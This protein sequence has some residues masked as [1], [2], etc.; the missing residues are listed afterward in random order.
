VE[1]QN[2][3]LSEKI[4]SVE[5]QN[6]RLINDNGRVVTLENENARLSLDNRQLTQEVK[7][8]KETHEVLLRQANQDGDTIKAFESGN[9]LLVQEKMK[10]VGEIKR[11][12]QQLSSL[13]EDKKQL[14]DTASH[15]QQENRRLDA[16][17][18][19]DAATIRRLKQELEQETAKAVQL[20][21][22][23][24]TLSAAI[25]KHTED[26]NTTAQSPQVLPIQVAGCLKPGGSLSWGGGDIVLEK[27]EMPLG[28]ARSE[29]QLYFRVGDDRKILIGRRSGSPFVEKPLVVTGTRGQLQFE[30]IDITSVLGHFPVIWE[31]SGIEFKAT[32]KPLD[33]GRK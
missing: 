28:L 3:N 20:Q 7:E 17:N 29:V 25:K 18:G 2:W 6:V 19:Q 23:K 12:T 31:L 30:V 16:E 21:A 33:A 22:E 11:L 15:L 32:Y 26:G 14:A 24:V 10:N 1:A 13:A 9:Q 27:Y 4:N 8:A 5:Q